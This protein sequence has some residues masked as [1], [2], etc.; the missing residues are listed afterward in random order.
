M[1]ES[2]VTIAQSRSDPQRA[3]DSL[4]LYRARQHADGYIPY[5]LGSYLEETIVTRGEHTSSGPLLAWITWEVYRRTGDRAFLAEM[6][7]TCA[8]NY[9]WWVRNRDAD[10][11]GLCEWNGFEV[12]E[13]LRDSHNVI[14][15]EVLP[16]R[17][18]P[19]RE[20][21][22]L[23]LNCMLV[24]EA[25][26]LAEMAHELHRPEAREWKDDADARRDRINA[27][28]WDETTG[29][30][31]HCYREDNDIGEELKRRE[32]I[33]LLPLWAR[34]APK[35]RARRLIAAIAD[36]DD[37]GRPYG[38]PSL[39]ARDPFYT[40]ETGAC[41]WNGPVWPQWSYMIGCGLRD[42]GEHELARTVAEHQLAAVEH[43]LGTTHR[44]WEQYDPDQL[45]PLNSN[46]NYYW[47]GIV[48]E[49][50][51]PFDK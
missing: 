5:R 49:M 16:R 10:G 30:Y 36:P 11:D 48:L 1:H 42:C 23:D 28:M 43:Y 19:P 12:L 3:M 2:I 33:G 47:T 13:C 20:L 39:S 6:Y 31:Y 21:E 26:H 4:R 32:F 38:I 7:P 9:R 14:F 25:D 24:S 51:D 50:I 18:T 35:D 46:A 37:F 15:Q 45:V 17:N 44:L 40:H 29:F 34:V 8:A 27:C 41:R 22:A